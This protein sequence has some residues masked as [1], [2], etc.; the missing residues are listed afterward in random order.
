MI[1]EG[2]SDVFDCQSTIFCSLK[3]IE[4]KVEKNK[5][6]LEEI[7][8][9]LDHQAGG[10]QKTRRPLGW[11]S[12]FP[13]ENDDCFQEW[14][15]FLCNEKNFDYAVSYFSFVSNCS[16][17]E[18]V[19]N[20]LSKVLTNKFAQHFNWVGHGEKRA[21]RNTLTKKLLYAYPRTPSNSHEEKSMDEATKNWLKLAKARSNYTK[22]AM[23]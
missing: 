1:R 17:S 9:H 6:H 13:L 7:L 15:K 23:K 10:I 2:E 8:R 4:L 19:R 11:P 20:F 5:L 14:E 21:F 12:N 22:R 18:N 3:R 16:P